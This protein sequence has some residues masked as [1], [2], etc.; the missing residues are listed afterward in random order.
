MSLLNFLFAFNFF[1]EHYRKV[2]LLQ[3]ADNM[4]IRIGNRARLAGWVALGLLIAAPADALQCVPYARAA[5]GIQ[6]TGDAWKWWNAAAGVY[7]RGHAPRIGA[8]MV[9][10]KF[11]KMRLGHVA[12]VA[13]IVNAR[14]VLVDHANWAHGDISTMVAVRDMSR[15]NDWSQVQV[16]SA[17]I[18]DFGTHAYPTYGFIYPRHR[19]TA[20]K[21]V[22]AD[23]TA[24]PPMAVPA[25]ATSLD[26]ALAAAEDVIASLH[27]ITPAEGAGI[28][29]DSFEEAEPAAGPQPVVQSSADLVWAGDRDAAQRARSGQ[30]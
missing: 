27:A 24:Q 3:G 4:G 29:I 26:A 15:H 10:R 30:Y 25:V 21:T 16:W 12:V 5:S 22:P 18:R 23:A 7:E 11:G 6:L 17:D 1:H 20:L 13:K 19:M 14:E 9:F 8:V 28:D 2:R